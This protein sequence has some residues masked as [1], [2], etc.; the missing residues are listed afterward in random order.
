MRLKRLTAIL[1]C[2]C[3]ALTLLP[4]AALAAGQTTEVM[5]G[6]V[7]LYGSADTPVYAKTDSSSGTV[8]PGGSEDSYNIKWDGATL[9]LN[10]AVITQGP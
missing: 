7:G 5:V 10:N 6:G 1:L 4:T 3:M 9:T 2:L 8:T